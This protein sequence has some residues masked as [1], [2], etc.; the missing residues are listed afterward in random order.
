MAL[1]WKAAAGILIA[2]L[3]GLSMKRQD[4]SLLL[5]LAVCTMAMGTA[6]V[7]LEPVLDF[8]RELEAWSSFQS[9]IL[10]ILMKALGIGL[11]AELAA[12]VCDDAGNHSLC[13]A[14][15]LLGNVTILYLSLPV[16]RMMLQLIHQILGE[17]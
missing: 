14:V 10:A 1:F 3:L 5:T 6:L 11:T 7:Y 15:Q 12:A 4:T 2:L 13:K 16:F 9:D 17:V 8:L